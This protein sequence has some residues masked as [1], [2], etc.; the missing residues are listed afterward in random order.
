MYFNKSLFFTLFLCL[1]VYSCQQK[2]IYEDISFNN[3]ILENA[4]ETLA[5]GFSKNSGN[6]ELIL[7]EILLKDLK[8]YDHWGT[9]DNFKSTFKSHL[10]LKE[11][12]IIKEHAKISPEDQ[13]K[14]YQSFTKLV[15]TMY[16]ISKY[17]N[18]SDMILYLQKNPICT[19]NIPDQYNLSSLI[20]EK[21]DNL[22]IFYGKKA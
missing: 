20:I 17:N 7:K 10:Y 3:N 22:L 4:Y 2:D 6:L 16:S 11:E 13:A 5:S 18:L 14:Y 21:N 9:D 8:W 15:Y 19:H 1:F 12:D